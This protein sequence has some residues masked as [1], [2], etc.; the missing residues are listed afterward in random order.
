MTLLT[1]LYNCVC[2]YCV[3]V[4]ICISHIHIYVHAYMKVKGL[5]NKILKKLYRC[6]SFI[7]F[8]LLNI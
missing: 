8:L 5:L 3:Y 7:L 6:G 4:C 1:V 2:V